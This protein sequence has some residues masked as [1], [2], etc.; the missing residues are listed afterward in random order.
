MASPDSPAP[1]IRDQVQGRI[2][3][4]TT[5][6]YKNYTIATVVFQNGGMTSGEFET[7]RKKWEIS[8]EQASMY[9]Y[10]DVLL[11]HSEE[12]Y[13]QMALEIYNGTNQASTGGASGSSAVLPGPGIG[14][15][16]QAK[17]M[18][19]KDVCGSLSSYS[20]IH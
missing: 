14:T 10:T 17:K 7:F 6:C 3:D 13:C 16:T 11:R 19:G 4:L 2:T 1:C 8:Q 5:Y 12:K 15:P 18:S 20:S 9:L